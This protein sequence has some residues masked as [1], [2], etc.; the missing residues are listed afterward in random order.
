MK[1]ATFNINGINKRLANLVQWLDESK[2]DVV[3]LQE[4][5]CRDREFPHRA[6]EAAGYGA[7]A[8]GQGPHHGVALLARGATP[9][10]TRRALPGDPTDNEARYIE[11]AVNGVLFCCIYLP[12]GNPQPGPKFDYKLAWFARL[13]QHASGLQAEQVPAVL[14]GDFN[15][16]PTDFDIYSMRSWTRNALVQPEPRRLF[17]R[18]L[19]IGWTDALRTLYPDDP[20][21]TF[22]HYYRDAWKRNAG[23]R[24]DHFLLSTTLAPRLQRGGVDR[25]VRGR[26]NASDHAPAWVEVS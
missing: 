7:I 8:R 14:L 23:W 18:L 10:E 24:L 21:Y 22:W 2:P 13:I 25:D 9:L 12:N 17:A 20:M 19:E 1:I 16:V 5:K 15:V 26:E 11:A 3:A 4:I 6:L